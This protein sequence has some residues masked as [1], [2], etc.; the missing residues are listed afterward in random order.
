MNDLTGKYFVKNTINGEYSDFSSLFDGLRILKID[1]M[2]GKGKAKNVYTA[3]WEYDED[4][5]FAI[6]MQNDSDPIKIIRECTDIDITFIIKG[7]YATNNI[8]VSEQHE[9]FINYML[10]SDLWI[11]SGYVN[12]VTAH[13]VCVNDYKPTTEKY[14]R[15]EDS[16]VIGTITLHLLSKP[17]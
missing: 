1:G 11:K 4:E 2:M 10:G 9:A 14:K 7:S 8:D 16:Y 5:D 15:G 6:V 13:C 17:A 3:S 12:D